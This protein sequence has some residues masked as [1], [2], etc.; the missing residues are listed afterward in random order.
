LFSFFCCVVR[1]L[2]RG[3]GCN[4]FATFGR[5]SLKYLRAKQ[6]PKPKVGGSTPRRRIKPASVNST[7]RTL[8]TNSG[9]PRAS[10]N[11]IICRLKCDWATFNRSAARLKFPA[12][13]T[14]MKYLRLF[15]LTVAKIF[16]GSGLMPMFALALAT[17]IQERADSLRPEKRNRLPIIGGACSERDNSGQD[18]TI[19]GSCE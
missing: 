8:R 11:R 3:N 16:F 6:F 1:I 7:C 4:T 17:I 10:S 5:K 13:L 15:R 2:R 14:A 18:L 19:S 9:W 12:L